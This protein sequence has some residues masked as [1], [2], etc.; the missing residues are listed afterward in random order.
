MRRLYSGRLVVV[1]KRGAEQEHRRNDDVGDRGGDPRRQVPE[2]LEQDVKDGAGQEDDDRQ[3]RERAERVHEIG[4]A[5][6]ERPPERVGEPATLD[7]RHRNNEADEREPRETREDEDARKERERDECD[8]AGGEG[9]AKLGPSRTQVGGDRDRQDV[10]RRQDDRTRE[11]DE[12]DLPEAREVELDGEHVQDR[13]SDTDREGGPR[14]APVQAQRLGHHLS[15]RAG[16]R[17][18]RR[19]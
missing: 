13:R 3:R 17:R 9:G 16:L 15:D 19:R 12:D 14:T 5:E 18:Q 8:R 10:R 11:R 7:Q 4:A 2:A 6:L 1:Q